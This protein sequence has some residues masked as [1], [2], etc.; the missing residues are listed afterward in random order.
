[1]NKSIDLRGGG[2][3]EVHEILIWIGWGLGFNSFGLGYY[4]GL[5]AVLSLLN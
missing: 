5:G 3:D 1:M 4:I 2:S